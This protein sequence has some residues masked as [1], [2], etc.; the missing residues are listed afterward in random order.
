MMDLLAKTIITPP[1]IIL[2]SEYLPHNLQY[3]NFFNKQRRKNHI[4]FT[5]IYILLYANMDNL[6]VGFSILI[7][8]QLLHHAIV[9]SLH[10][11]YVHFTT[12]VIISSDTV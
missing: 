11:V 1:K 3:E 5:N 6:I 7:L 4:Q 9:V 8:L 2:N 10:V 12:V